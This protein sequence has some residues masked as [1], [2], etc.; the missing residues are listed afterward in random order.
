MAVTMCPGNK[1]VVANS[2][3][4]TIAMHISV[5]CVYFF[6][7]CTAC[8]YLDLTMKSLHQPWT[9]PFT[10][11][12]FL[13][14]FPFPA[15]ITQYLLHTCTCVY[16][17]VFQLGYG[18][19]G[20]YGHPTSSTPNLDAMAQEGLV[21]THFYSAS[22]VCS[23]SRLACIHAYTLYSTV[24]CASFALKTHSLEMVVFCLW[25]VVW[26]SSI[27]QIFVM[28]Y[29]FRIVVFNFFCTSG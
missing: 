29:V 20:C 25:R 26:N 4:G 8:V 28:K 12:W 10:C 16:F 2:D 1:S 7:A 11:R 14:W 21:F 19:L 15:S 9:Y 6:D 24:F 23:P 22:S 27:W 17:F 5:L 13:I 18:D 3:V